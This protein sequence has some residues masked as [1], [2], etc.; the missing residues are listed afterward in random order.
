MFSSNTKFM[1]RQPKV[2]VI[3]PLYVIV[4]RFF[5]DLNRFKK[6][7][8]KNFEIIVV[9]DKKVNIGDHNVKIIYT[10]KKNTGP[11]EKRDLALKYV[12][13]EICA[14]IDD[15]A[16]PDKNWL[17]EIVRTLE[18]KS[19][20]AVGG[21]GIT[22][23]ED[24]YFAKLGG[25]VYESYL[26]GGGAQDRFVSKN[27]ERILYDWPA[28]N[29]AVR[30]KDLKQVGGY[31]N[32]FY[33]GEDTLLCLKLIQKGKRIL[34]NPKMIVY[35]HRRGLFGPHLKQIFNVGVHR[36][37]FAKVFPQTSRK[38]FYFIPSILTF[39]LLD[40]IILSIISSFWLR[41]TVFCFGLLYL[42]AFLSV[43][44]RTN[45]INSFIVAFGIIATHVVY[46]IGFLKGLLTR[47]LTR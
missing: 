33:G 9:S 16:Y 44:R 41:F 4:D 43:I 17:K 21:P 39:G 36:G 42:A 1:Q 26:T 14:F 40:L 30:T 31:G 24:R 38:F 13:G 45:I 28:Y 37:Y 5:K 23:P 12:N 8:Y 20:V 19:I 15:D 22:P 27:R 2:S 3:I 46:G 6:L 10:K 7:D 25:L 29:L 34:Y 47:K 18:E 11:A 35:H 32:S